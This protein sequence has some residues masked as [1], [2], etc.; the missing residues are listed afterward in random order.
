MSVF[1][2]VS[3]HVCLCV[4][5]TMSLCICPCIAGCRPSFDVINVMSCNCDT[6][7]GRHRFVSLGWIRS[8]FCLFYFLSFTGEKDRQEIWKCHKEN[9]LS[10]FH[11]KAFLPGSGAPALPVK[12][13]LCY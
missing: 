3:V 1:F 7:L 12:M 13:T 2:C 10:D 6:V 11:G 9:F 8:P 4:S 5:V